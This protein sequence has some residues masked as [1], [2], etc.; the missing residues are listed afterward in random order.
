M[1][2]NKY[3]NPRNF[4]KTISQLES[5]GGKDLE[6]PTMQEGIQAGTSAI[7][8]Y[9]LMPNT[10]KEII[11][12]RRN[13]GAMTQQLQDLDGMNPKEMKEYIEANP[14]VEDELANTLALKV[15]RNQMGDE[16]KAAFAWHQGDN[17]K[18]E[19]ISTQKLNDTNTVGGKYVE[20][21]RRIKDQLTQPQPENQDDNEEESEVE[22]N[23]GSNNEQE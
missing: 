7:G 21:F 9:G 6:H 12:N 5:S 8:K 2:T 3:A 15:L 19:D 18:P 11:N 14:D 10:V 17:L 4:L 22:D 20:K 1:P 13:N 16:D 23:T